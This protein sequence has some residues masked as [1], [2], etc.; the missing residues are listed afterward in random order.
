MKVKIGDITL[1]QFDDICHGVKGHPYR[2][3]NCPLMEYCQ[4]DE[5]SIARNLF[6]EEVEVDI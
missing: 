4:A 6:D 2:C 1:R 5:R 3:D